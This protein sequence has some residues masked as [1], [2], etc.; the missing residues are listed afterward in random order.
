MD[1]LLNTMNNAYASKIPSSGL[2]KL[3]NSGALLT[4]AALALVILNRMFTYPEVI[5]ISLATL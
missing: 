5:S 3:S 2:G 1:A 4:F